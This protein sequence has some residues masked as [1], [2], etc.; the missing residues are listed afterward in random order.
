M[1]LDGWGE[2]KGE[3]LATTGGESE[4]VALRDPDCQHEIAELSERFTVQ[5]LTNV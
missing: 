4:T 2:K 3:S 1:F 5:Y